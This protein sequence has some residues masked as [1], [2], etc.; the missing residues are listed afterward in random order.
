MNNAFGM[1]LGGLGNT[2]GNQFSVTGSGLGINPMGL[3]QGNAM[4]MNQ[5]LQNSGI[6]LGSAATGNGGG[7]GQFQN[8][9]YETSPALW[10]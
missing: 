10:I 3:A 1:S 8:Q 2:G 4:N 6:A 5:M 7:V 9:K